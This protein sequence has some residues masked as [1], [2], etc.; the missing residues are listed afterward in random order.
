MPTPWRARLF[1]RLGPSAFAGMT[2]GR[3]LQVLR[4]N[5]FDIDRP[6]W[7]RMAVITLAAAANTPVAAWENL[8]FGRRIARTRVEAP[9]FVLGIFRSGTTF[10]HRILSQDARMAAPS[11]VQTVFPNTFLSVEGLCRWGIGLA[12]PG[13]R[14]QDG[15]KQSAVEPHEDEWAIA[16]S[17]GRT[18][19]LDLAFP[20]RADHYRRYYQL[21]SLSETERAEWCGSLDRFLRKVTLRERRPL[22]LK[23]PAHTGRIATL[24][25]M[26]PD[27]RFVHIRRDPFEVFQSW[28]HMVHRL[29]P[30]M[31]MQRTDHSN[32]EE[33]ILAVYRQVYDAYFDQRDLV[34]AGRL[35]ETSFENLEA[36]P[37]GTTRAIY[38]ALDLPAF[39]GTEEAIREY[40]GGLVDY[41]RNR[42]PPLEQPWRDRV[43]DEWQRCFDEWGYP[44]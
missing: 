43:V 30:Q 17:S 19:L 4:D 20:R 25:E 39:E 22:V 26:Y 29:A 1:N 40:V 2:I 35:F 6:Y 28:R 5:G 24:L 11:L 12:M 21:E 37:V 8:R 3:W 18:F 27:A 31:E 13:K 23:S 14:P 32:L 16:G 15:V 10:L 38:E 9:L 44:R 41:D 36:D 42:Y 7:G 33:D 34:P